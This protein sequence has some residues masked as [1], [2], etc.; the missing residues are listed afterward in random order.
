MINGSWTVQ[1]NNQDLNQRGF[2][3]ANN[4]V[5]PISNAAGTANFSLNRFSNRITL[6]NLTRSGD[7]FSLEATADPG[8]DYVLEMA[9]SL[10]APIAWIPVRTNFQSGANFQVTDDQATGPARYYRMR[11]RP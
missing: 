3:S 9:T 6:G 1:V 11:L 4:Q 7:Q 8:R 5:V 10:R 2:I